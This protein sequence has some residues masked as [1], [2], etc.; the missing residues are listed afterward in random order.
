MSDIVVTNDN[1]NLILNNFADNDFLGYRR[2]DSSFCI[3]VIYISDL[4]L[5]YKYSDD[6]DKYIY[7][8]ARSLINSLI[9]I[10]KQYELYFPYVVFLG[11]I[12]DDREDV[13]LFYRY[14]NKFA[15]RLYNKLSHRYYSTRLYD[16]RNT[17]VILGNHEFMQFDT[18][19]DGVKWYKDRLSYMGYNVLFNEYMFGNTRDMI[20]LK[21][22]GVIVFGGTGFAGLNAKYNADNLVCSKNFDRKEEIRQ[23]KLFEKA[24]NEAVRFAK[25]HC[26]VLL[27]FSHYQYNDCLKKYN[28]QTI[29]FSGH[30]H[31]NVVSNTEDLVLYANNQV[32]LKSTNYEFKHHMVGIITNPYSSLG[33][34]WYETNLVNYVQF[35]DYLSVML[36]GWK[37][38][39]KKI[40][41][42]NGKLYLVKKHEVYG[43]FVVCYDKD[44]PYSFICNGG[45]LKKIHDNYDIDSIF[46]D[47][48][49]VI[50][51]YL[52]L[53]CPVRKKQQLL[54]DAFKQLGLRGR[55]HGLIVDIDYWNHVMINPITGELQYY[56]SEGLDQDPILFK[57]LLEV[58]PVKE[59][60][61]DK[62]NSIIAS[63]NVLMEKSCENSFINN[64]AYGVSMKINAIQFLF[65]K[66][67]LRRFDYDLVKFRNLL[68]GKE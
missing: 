30:T 2:N 39:S 40:K 50:I 45:R 9:D 68:E 5:N 6:R 64:E 67:L 61:A 42:H 14:Y 33:D 23:S 63:N 17:Y 26:C 18:I 58:E 46:N 66:R 25:K 65:D 8:V 34:G 10:I 1:Y 41:E 57:S 15:N 53:V 22:I 37:L 43:F 48:D 27:C 24:Y 32:G 3:D 35:M 60:E 49:S 19:D 29:F 4:H 11:D 56:Y 12:A 28:N 21:C 36:L 54:S 13:Y 47:F 20:R 7:N 59:L 44:K 55:I 51:G 16:M 31:I 62:L 38:I 52:N